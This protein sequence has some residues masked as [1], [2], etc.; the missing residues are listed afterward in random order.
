[1]VGFGPFCSNLELSSRR[2]ILFIVSYG[3]LLLTNTGNDSSSICCYNNLLFQKHLSCIVIL[4]SLQ[5]TVEYMYTIHLS[6][7]TIPRSKSHG[8]TVYGSPRIAK[9]LKLRKSPL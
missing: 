2:C 9:K 8:N 6:I 3:L 7:Q 4:F 5:A 1:M